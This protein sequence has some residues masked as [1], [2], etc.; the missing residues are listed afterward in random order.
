MYIK[1]HKQLKFESNKFY[2][3]YPKF[4]SNISFLSSFFIFDFGY[5]KNDLETNISKLNHV[6]SMAWNDDEI[7][8]D[9][10]NNLVYI[11][12]VPDF[13]CDEEY[14]EIYEEKMKGK[15]L[16]QLYQ[17]NLLDHMTISKENFFYILRTW[18]KYLDEKPPFL[19]LYENENN[20][21]DLEPFESKNIMDEFV[22]NHSLK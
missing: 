19:L 8:I 4:E 17:E 9:Q 14:D 21:F 10:K 15:S 12:I 2:P 3:I 13:C 11:G 6:D 20:W 7:V 5:I 16:L 1:Q 18:K 22:I